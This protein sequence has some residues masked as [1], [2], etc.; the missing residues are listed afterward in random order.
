VN[1]QG[2][3]NFDQASANAGYIKWLETR[4]VT[5]QDLARRMNLPLGRQVEVWLHGGVRL[6]GRLHLQ[7]EILF[8]EEDRVRHLPLVVD[9]VSFIYR[10][11]ESCVRLD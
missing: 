5:M 6:R 3:F 11:M 9:R 2:E 10:D 7:E 4:R 1:T 8:I